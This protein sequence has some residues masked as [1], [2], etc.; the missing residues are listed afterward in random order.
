MQTDENGDLPPCTYLSQ[1]FSPAKWNYD[2]YNWE[3]LAI[4]HALDHWCHYLQGMSHL[5]TL[6]TV[7]VEEPPTS[8][9]PFSLV[10]C[11]LHSHFSFND[12]VAI[13]FPDLA[14]DLDSQI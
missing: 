3:L 7:T 12:F 6:L 10:D 13:A 2:I 8:F 11:M 9:S 4:I 14:R 1:T 5:V